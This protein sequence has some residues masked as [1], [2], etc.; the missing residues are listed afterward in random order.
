MEIELTDQG[1]KK[2][3]EIKGCVLKSNLQ[4][5]ENEICFTNGSRHQLV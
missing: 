3:L 5:A 4:K 1:I 2:K